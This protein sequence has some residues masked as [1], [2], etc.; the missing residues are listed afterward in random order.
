MF[1]G[2][3]PDDLLKKIGDKQSLEISKQLRTLREERLEILNLPNP[4]PHVEIRA[5]YDAKTKLTGGD[6]LRFDRQTHGATAIGST[7]ELQMFNIVY[8]FLHDNVQR[9]SFDNHNSAM[10]I[11][12]NVGVNYN[13]A[14]WD[15]DRFAFGNGDQETFRTFWIQNIASHE[16][17]HAV[18]EWVAG[19]KYQ[20]EAGALN[21]HISDVFAACVDQF[22]ANQK[23]E[24]ASWLVGDGVWMGHINGVALRTFKDELAY[25]D[26]W[27]GRDPQGKHMRDY[28]YTRKDNGGVHLNSGIPNHAFY[29]FC[30][31]TGLESW[32]VPFSIWYNAL[33]I[34]RPD[35]TFAQFANHT[36]DVCPTE[37]K[38]KLNEAWAKVGIIPS[39]RIITENPIT[40]VFRY[41]ISFIKQLCV[42]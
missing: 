11:Y 1:C 39:P 37:Y 25:N 14:F 32:T 34:C 5:L 33:N 6:L 13:N 26:T 42:K 20:G 31:I 27:V 30:I 28:I 19:L 17:M 36:M 41:I 16:A 12:K 8:D 23:P 29:Q 38:G 3:I 40:K 2:I 18:T 4:E 15:G 9:E 22:K 10:K 24:E 21:E 35:E 7:P